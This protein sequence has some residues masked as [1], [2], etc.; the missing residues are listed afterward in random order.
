[1]AQAVMQTAAMLT[2]TAE[3]R[4]ITGCLARQ[5]SRR[6]LLMETHGV[7][8]YVSASKRLREAKRWVHAGDEM[9]ADSNPG[10]GDGAAHALPAA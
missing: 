10:Q 9:A 6:A 5:C 7:V 4:D 1:M 3:K 2:D 8:S